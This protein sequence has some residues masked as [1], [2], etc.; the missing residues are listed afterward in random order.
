MKKIVFLLFSLVLSISIYAQ[1]ESFE[2]DGISYKKL[3]SNTVE[4]E[5]VPFYN[6]GEEVSVTIPNEITYKKKKYSVT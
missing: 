2:V 1:D 3:T 6:Y 5:Q 4:V